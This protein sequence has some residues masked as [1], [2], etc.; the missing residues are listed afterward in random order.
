MTENYLR[1]AP[2]LIQNDLNLPMQITT[3]PVRNDT[4]LYSPIASWDV[5]EMKLTYINYVPQ[6]MS[7]MTLDYIDPVHLL[8]VWNNI[9]L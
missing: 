9:D 2:W 6:Y 4:E 5:S 3:L 1:Q 7:G 8:H